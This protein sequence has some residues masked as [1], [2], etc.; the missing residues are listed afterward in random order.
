[1]EQL[2]TQFRAMGSPCEFRFY[3]PRKCILDAAAKRCFDH[4]QTLEQKYSRYISTSLLQEINQY[5]ATRTVAIDPETYFLLQYSQACFEQSDGLFDITSGVLRKIWHTTMTRL[6]SEAMRQACMRNIGF[7]KLN[8]D[9]TSIR[10]AATE[11]EIDLGGVVKEYAADTALNIAKETGVKAGVIN[12]GGDL[13]CF[14]TCPFSNTWQI[15][16]AHP[17]DHNQAIRQIKLAEGAI[18]TSGNYERFYLV[19]GKRYSHLMDPRSGWPIQGL[20]SVTVI[21]P[22]AVVAGSLSSIAMLHSKPAALTWLYSLGI[23]FLAIDTDLKCYGDLAPDTRKPAY[24][25]AP[26]ST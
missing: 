1:M 17:E 10:F 9:S 3:G 12:L 11:M 15:G 6:P 13:C 24:E 26:L 2:I 16:I 4:I 22:Q 23:E 20:I 8:Y 5:A 21:A 18:S 25:E 7:E 14:G 19:E